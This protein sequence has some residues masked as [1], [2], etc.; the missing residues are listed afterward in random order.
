MAKQKGASLPVPTMGVSAVVL[1][2]D[3][4]VLMVCRN[5]SPACGQW[6]IPGGRMEPGESLMS[7]C[8]R[9]VKEETGIDVEVKNILA[10]VERRVE[11]FHYVI[12]DFLATL[13]QTNSSVPFAQT[14]VS[15]ARWVSV[16]ELGDLN[17]VDG[18]EEIIRRAYSY[19]QKGIS[20]GLTDVD[21]KGTDF[22]A[23]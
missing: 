11:N 3:D 6:S 15:D 7:A 4:T 8:K 5:K 1:N 16:N 21:G 9:E 14:D 19:N 23:L 18:L 22:I 13:E 17:L 20:T 10:V 12:V 2:D